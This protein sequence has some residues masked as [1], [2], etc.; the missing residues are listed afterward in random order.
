LGYNSRILT[1]T[2]VSACRCLLIYREMLSIRTCL[3]KWSEINHV[4]AVLSL[5]EETGKG[6]EA[7]P[8]TP[9]V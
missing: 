1:I 4:N 6:T 8:T 7:V 9:K 2:S 3:G 5:E